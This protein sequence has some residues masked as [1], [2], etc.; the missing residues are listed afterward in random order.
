MSLNSIQLSPT[1]I[2]ELYRHSLVQLKSPVVA[3][4]TKPVAAFNIL[5]KNQQH[6]VIIVNNNAVAFVPDEEL[7]FLLGVLSACKLNMDDVGILN[8]SKKPS[9]DY[10]KIA[11][12]L[13]A[14]KL[15]LFGTAP[16]AIKLPLSFPHYQVQ[17]YNEQTYLSAPALSAIQ[18]DKAEKTK[19]WNSLKQ[20][21]SI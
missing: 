19:L 3:T 2:Q 17:R 8:I 12:E 1:S 15:I 20:I 5:G 14:E 13:H 21:F 16:D 7:N 9:P 10:K 11:A 4:E 18:L 6:I